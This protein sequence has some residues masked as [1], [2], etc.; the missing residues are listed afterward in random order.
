ML[1][2]TKSDGSREVFV[3]EKL[4]RCLS[5]ALASA[6]FDE[7]HASALASAVR[8]HIERD[9]DTANLTSEYVFQ[10]AIAVLNQTGAT[11]AA[12]ELQKHYR[13]REGLRRRT[14]VFNPQ[15][16]AK[17]LKPWRKS[18]VVATL[19]NKHGVDAKVARVL[20]GEI[21]MR[22]FASGYQVIRTPLILEIVKN[23]LMAWGLIDELAVG[24]H[25][26]LWSEPVGS[27]WPVREE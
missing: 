19:R 26:E 27:K 2:I 13:E 17:G 3:E 6:S 21:E 24:R 1:L 8:I 18:A 23:E 11:Q 12:E 9:A 10:C 22:I 15:R 16:P 20:A 4:R 14:R 7:V 5:L 25:A